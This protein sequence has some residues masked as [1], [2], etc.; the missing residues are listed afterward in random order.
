VGL[1]MFCQLRARYANACMALNRG[2]YL[3][4]A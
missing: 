3:L 4:I 2:F 1:L